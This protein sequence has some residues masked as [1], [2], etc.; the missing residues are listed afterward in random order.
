MGNVL[1]AGLGRNP[2]RQAAPEPGVPDSVPA[3]TAG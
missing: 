2:A 1:S 3:R